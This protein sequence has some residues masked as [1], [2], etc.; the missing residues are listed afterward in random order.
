M[1]IENESTFKSYLEEGI[2]FF[3]GAGFSVDAL[4]MF[5][6]IPEKMPIGNKLRDEL[7]THFNRDPTSK[8]ELPQLC[9]IL[10]STKKEELNDFFRNRFKTID[11]DPLY[12]NIEYI[13]IKSIFTT[14]IDDL[15]YKI[16]EKSDI[17]YINDTDLRGSAMPGSTAIDYI[18]LHGSILHE[19][20]EGFDFT[21]IEISS[22]F[23]RNRGKWSDYVNRIQ[24]TPTLYW[25]YRLTDAGVLQAM[26]KDTTTSREKS[27]AWIVLRSEDEES[28]EYFSSLG[29]Q[30]IIG[31][32]KDL[33]EYFGKLNFTQQSER[34]SSLAENKI[35]YKFK[36]YALPDL[37]K[38]SVRSKAE[39]YYGAEPTWYD[40]CL[41]D[42]HKTQYFHKAKNEIFGN[43]HVILIGSA[44]TGK[45]TLLKQL[46]VF[47][48]KKYLCLYIDEITYEKAQ[49]LKT[50]IE[51]EQKKV[52][53]FIDNAA[54]AWSAIDILAK[55][56]LIQI[57]VAE[58][59]YFFESIAHRFPNNQYMRIDISNMCKLDIQAV[60]N[61]I[62]FKW[63][64]KNNKV[65]NDLINENQDPTF[66][67]VMSV[68]YDKDSNK[69]SNEILINRFMSAMTELKIISRER[70]DL[71]LLVC[72]LYA[73]R[74]PTSLDVAGSFL[75][76]FHIP[77]IDVY[78]HLNKMET[79]ISNYEGD[80]ADDRQ[81][82]Y[83]PRSRIVAEQF[84]ER[85]NNQEL[86]D[87]LVRFHSQVSTM[88]IPRYDNFKRMAY[89]A[90]LTSRAF[91][92]WQDGLKFY[93]DF[94][95]RDHS[96][97]F[98][99]QAAIYL[100]RKKQFAL[101]FKWIDEAKIIA[102]GHRKI[103]IDN[104]YAVIL[105]GANYD[106]IAEDK[107]LITSLDESME[108]LTKC[109]ESDRKK[110]YHAKVFADQA[111]KYAMAL[112]TSDNS[113]IYV[114][115]AITWLNDR[116]IIIPNRNTNNLLREL[117]ALNRKFIEQRLH[118]N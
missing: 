25:G 70:Y 19:P 40:I 18:A 48:S 98:K 46:A 32:T 97:S 78:N 8:L 113:K 118:S 55:S 114:K 56:K 83:V 105:F 34:N 88:K 22:S 91:P 10:K 84:I 17:K 45:T 104:T 79:L 47:F 77:I 93:E 50:D 27:D 103:S 66:F 106:K 92:N 53:L 108:I 16:F 49:L 20:S 94:L 52:I 38:L 69:V 95:Y 1:K 35:K 33:L 65:Y 115:K 44:V 89:D 110:P 57:V 116:S 62:P 82:Y 86:A 41:N 7:L 85:I 72:Y 37:A 67:E 31:E 80:L 76:D 3:L 75:Y 111:I 99:Q 96:H 4:G 51:Q 12:K 81:S 102:K 11:Y 43:N 61:K 54:D 107:N 14:N 6:N 36:E 87:L 24:H 117:N 13:N 64:K 28:K 59:D 21:S 74:V 42:L 23:E 90:N 58:R 100:N 101:A 71:L 63:Y 68:T 60:E 30:I 39:F 112:P 15:I 29:F 109:F 5:N 9:H 26:S 2:N 73:C